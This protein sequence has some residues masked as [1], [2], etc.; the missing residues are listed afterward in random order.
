MRFI[1]RC[2][3]IFIASI[4]SVLIAK[5]QEGDT[6]NYKL[7]KNPTS[8]SGV[9]AWWH[10]MDGN[11]TREGIRKDLEAMAQQGIT[12]VT[13]LNV[14]MYGMQ[15]QN[16]KNIK[17]D[18]PEW[19]EMFRYA[20]AKA[21]SL[22]I[23]VGAQNC[24]GWSTSG[25]PWITP[26]Y[27]MKEIS[28]NKTLVCGGATLEKTLPQP[29]SVDGFYRDVAVLAIKI[30]RKASLFIHESPEIY[31]NGTNTNQQLY[32]G[33]PVGGAMVRE[34]DVLT[35]DFKD[36]FVANKISIY[37]R[38]EFMWGSAKKVETVETSYS[39]EAKNASGIFVKVAD[40]KIE[41][42][43][44]TVCKNIPE[45]KS[46]SFKLKVTGMSN[47]DE[48]YIG[49]L[50]LLKGDEIPLYSSDIPYHQAKTESVQNAS[51]DQYF[52]VIESSGTKRPIQ[53]EDI[54][55]IS[56]NLDING[57]LTWEVPSGN[58]EIIRFGYTIT[59][60]TNVPATATG[61]GLEC[62]KMD[63]TA[64]NIHFNNYP[65]KLIDCAGKYAGNTFKFILVDSWECHFQN[66]TKAFPDEFEKL[67]GYSI[68]KWIPV[69]CGEM[70]ESSK[71]TESFLYDYR[72]TIATLI[73]NNYFK[74][75]ADLCHRSGL[76]MHGEVIYAGPHLPPIDELKAYSYTDMPM[77]EFWANPNKDFELVYEGTPERSSNFVSS[78][79]L[80]YDKKIVGAEAY[81]G[82]ASYSDSPWKLKPYGDWAY[83]SGI[84]Q[85]IL[86]SYIHQPTDSIPGMAMNYF[87]GQPF[88][89]LNSYWEQLSGWTKYQARIQSV[90]QNSTDANDVLYYVGDRLPQ[91]TL[92]LSD[93]PVGYGSN[94]CN[95]DILQN[96][97]QVKDHKIEFQDG[98]SFSLLVLPRQEGMNYQTLLRL[99][100]M[101]QQGAYVYGEKPSCLYSLADEKNHRKDF[102]RIVQ[103]IW[104]NN[105]D[106]NNN[107][108]EHGKGKVLWGMSLKEALE[109]IEL[110][111]DFK[112][113][114]EHKK[115]I[116]FIHKRS[117]NKEIYFVAN[118]LNQ[119]I[120]VQCEFRVKDKIPQVWNP[121][122]GEVTSVK[123]SSGFQ[124]TVVPFD[125]KPM[126]SVFFVFQDKVE[127]HIA[128]EAEI[129]N[130][131][132]ISKFEGTIDFNPVYKADIQPVEINELISLSDFDEPE[133]KYFAGKARY[134]ISFML[135]QSI[136]AGNDYYLNLGNFDATATVSLNGNEIGE[137]WSPQQE[138]N[139]KNQ[140]QQGK[141]KLEITVAIPYRNRII[142]DIVQYGELK[143]LWT[144]YNI[145]WN[146]KADLPL[147]QVGLTGPLKI[148][149]KNISAK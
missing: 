3:I 85:M 108:I 141:N 88:N 86:H 125:F 72:R 80:F 6:L 93:L 66:W 127:K 50:E 105:A 146:M 106:G 89:R 102:E 61:R 4:L 33:C 24:D 117:N 91:Y 62:D 144:S 128:K 149:K 31:T 21:D 40:F 43:N 118:Q 26:E 15:F 120:S 23:T 129:I 37:P 107:I 140:I 109:E 10:W 82:Y 41:G 139:I 92:S 14:G 114:S 126:E 20:L 67:N 130:E 36:D 29:Y 113:S 32:D 9:H 7:F 74:Y 148:T 45:T 83:C 68:N 132:E 59:G 123:Y 22:H 8:S 64:F 115:D 84:N 73:E 1:R 54:I 2:N 53:S 17:F 121:L 137:L 131:F 30:E 49:E 75:F 35:I 135:D 95:F 94:I 138:L 34:G 63:T 13:I 101:I 27:G 133:I 98:V 112:T 55:D 60:Q 110:Q 38:K 16:L 71:N 145:A 48:F 100:E 28:W 70:V 58:W 52:N 119:S 116:P 18:S 12:Q 124:S 51:V 77:S 39:L 142:G 42:F 65:R 99:E 47:R 111:A 5:G 76:E 25:G 56:K 44:K 69:L 134:S 122:T 143:S 96:K 81:T 57:T 104:G 19:Y 78:A 97:L 90:L 46:K 103:S 79:A 147:M 11:I 87:F 136:E